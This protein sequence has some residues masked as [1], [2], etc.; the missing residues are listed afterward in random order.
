M[1]PHLPQED[2]VT[3]RSLAGRRGD[4]SSPCGETRR[5]RSRAGR[6]GVV[7]H[8]RGGEAS[9]RSRAG[10]RGVASFTRGETRRRLVHTRGDA[11][12]DGTA[13]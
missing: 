13:R 2:K 3:P 7:V 8:A 1:T 6:R 9:P 10:R 12:F 4:A 11:D 5:R